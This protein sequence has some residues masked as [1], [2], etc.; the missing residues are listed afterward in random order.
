VDGAQCRCGTDGGA[1]LWRALPPLMEAD[2]AWPRSDGRHGSDGVSVIAPVRPQ[3]SRWSARMPRVATSPHSPYSAPRPPFCAPKTK[4]V[5]MTRAHHHRRCRSQRMPAS[6][7]IAAI[8]SPTLDVRDS[9]NDV[10][11][12][13]NEQSLYYIERIAYF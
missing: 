4:G 12:G 13:S 6:C 8:S 5:V 1:P 7:Q 10:F 3:S 2:A 11:E 9:C